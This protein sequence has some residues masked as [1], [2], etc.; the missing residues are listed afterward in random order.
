MA[1]RCWAIPRTCR[2]PSNGRKSGGHG[3]VQRAGRIYFA[4]GGDDWSGEG[5]HGF[6]GCWSNAQVKVS[7]T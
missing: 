7:M 3:D 5:G 4:G 2:C 6:Q 1:A